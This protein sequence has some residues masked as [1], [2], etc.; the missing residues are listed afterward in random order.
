MVRQDADDEYDQKLLDDVGK[1][2]W[3]LVGIPADDEGP[4]YV[5]SVGIFHT[6][7]HP[8]ICIIGL[9]DSSL[10]A[11][12]VNG[13]G[14][15][16]RAGDVLEDWHAN[17]EVL[18]EHACIFR[19]VDRTHY[20]EYFGFARWFH[21][22]DDFPILQ[23]VWPDGTGRFPWDAHFAPGLLAAQPILAIAGDWPFD[24]AKNTAVITTS[25]VLDEAHPILLVAHDVDGD[26]QCLCGTTNDSEDGRVVSLATIVEMDPTVAELSNLPIGTRAKR[27]SAEHRWIRY[28]D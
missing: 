7:G 10:M 28:Q 13:I 22:G 19:E 12:I 8:E 3:H 26:W 5:F 2:G 21:E 1:F 20:A 9:N 18:E 14:E 11:Q 17:D 24:E 23:C 15:L 25:R 16:I 4:A 6:F 27:Q